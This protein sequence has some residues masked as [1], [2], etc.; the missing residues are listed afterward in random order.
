M[1][2]FF[3]IMTTVHF[4]CMQKEKTF[5]TVFLMSLLILFKSIKYLFN[6][7]NEILVHRNVSAFDFLLFLRIFNTKL[8]KKS[9][10]GIQENGITASSKIFKLIFSLIFC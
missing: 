1:H 10:K 3:Y 2:F 8:K 9:N 6:A 5:L 4:K 7:N